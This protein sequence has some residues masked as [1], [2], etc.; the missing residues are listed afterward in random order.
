[1]TMQIPYPDGYPEQFQP[2]GLLLKVQYEVIPWLHQQ[3]VESDMRN[4]NRQER[5]MWLDDADD[6]LN[7]IIMH[8]ESR[9]LFAVMILDQNFVQTGSLPGSKKSILY[10]HRG[11]PWLDV[12]RYILN[13]LLNDLSNADPVPKKL[14]EWN[15]LIHTLLAGFPERPIKWVKKDLIWIKEEGRYKMNKRKEDG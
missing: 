8:I 11:Q 2:V 5:L 1:M 10:R 4:Q 15:S 13:E 9:P 7:T 14:E 12:I 3:A 6:W